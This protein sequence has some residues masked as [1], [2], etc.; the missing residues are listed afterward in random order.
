MVQSGGEWS[1]L[2][3][4][5]IL[6]RDVWYQLTFTMDLEQQRI[7]LSLLSKGPDLAA[8][9]ENHTYVH[10]FEKPLRVLGSAPLLIAGGD[11][12][13]APTTVASPS[14]TFNGK[15]DD[16]KITAKVGDTSREIIHFDFSLDMS[17]DAVRD[18]SPDGRTGQLINAPT[19]AVRGHNY[20]G[21]W[22]D[23]TVSQYGYGAIHFH[24]DDVD[25]ANW[26]TVFSV[27]LP[28]SLLSGFYAALVDD[29]KTHDYIPFFVSPKEDAKRAEVAFI[30]PTFTY[31]GKS[32]LSSMFLWADIK[33]EPETNLF[34]Q[35]MPTKSF[36][37]R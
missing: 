15:I 11:H 26:D 1:R 31:G 19:R 10:T 24:D 12:N 5:I 18:I 4:S 21:T 9:P 25:D 28:Q 2:D 30:V 34:Q 16:F 20:D 27:Q 22:V 7:E 35:C 33:R 8:I 23:W 17:A 3:T 29:G 36:T 13:L 32:R 37:T 6:T 14:T